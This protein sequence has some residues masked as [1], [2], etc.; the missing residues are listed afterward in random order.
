MPPGLPAPLRAFL[1]N[2][3]VV[4]ADSGGPRKRP[5]LGA[6]A[7]APAPAPAP[8]ARLSVSDA[9]GSVEDGPPAPAHGGASSGALSGGDSD[10][11]SHGVMDLTA[12]SKKLLGT[13]N[14][15]LEVIPSRSSLFSTSACGLN[16]PMHSTS[17]VS[18]R[19]VSSVRGLIQRLATER[20]SIA[21]ATANAEADVQA[22]TAKLEAAL[23][24]LNVLRA[25]C[26]ELRRRHGEALANQSSV[27]QRLSQAAAERQALLSS[28]EDTRRTIAQLTNEKDVVHGEL[29]DATAESAAE[30]ERQVTFAVGASSRRFS[31]RTVLLQSAIG[32]AAHHAKNEAAGLHGEI[33]TLSKI[34]MSL[35]EDK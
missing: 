21:A 31:M 27:E 32:R 16:R 4:Q 25:Q 8:A 12:A 7:A 1:S 13:Q 20:V 5:S 11:V 19:A 9:F 28:I 15:A 34:L 10:E 26:E 24:E 14:A 17:Q 18:E 2:G 3:G 33:E 23:E 30:K 35:N 22:Q 6:P 29:R